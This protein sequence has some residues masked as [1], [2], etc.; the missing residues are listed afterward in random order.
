[1]DLAYVGNHGFREQHSVDLNFPTA[2]VGAGWNASAVNT[3]IASAAT[4]YNKCTPDKAAEAG[5]YT[6]TIPISTTSFNR[7]A[8]TI[9]TI[10][11]CK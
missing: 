8:I 5:P 11:H 10:T 6:N 3:C 1:M 7:A 9:P 2:G 4:N